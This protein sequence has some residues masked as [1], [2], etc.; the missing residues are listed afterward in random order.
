[1]KQIKNYFVN[2]TLRMNLLKNLYMNFGIAYVQIR[3]NGSLFLIK[4]LA[5]VFL[6]NLILVLML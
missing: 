4:K 6:E 3:K 5:Q 2:L 1:M